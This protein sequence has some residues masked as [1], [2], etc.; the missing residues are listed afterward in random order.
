VGNGDFVIIPGIS[1]ANPIDNGGGNTTTGTTLHTC[2]AANVHN[3][4][5]TYGSMTD[6][7]GNVYKTIVIGTQEWMAENL[8]ASHYRNGDLIPLV[9]DDM[10]WD[11]LTTGATCWYNNDSATYNC[12]YGK[13]YNWYAVADPN[14][15]CPTGWHVPTYSEWSVLRNYFDDV[16]PYYVAASK[17]Q[18]L[19]FQYWFDFGNL[20]ATNESGF[21]AL[22]GGTRLIN[23]IFNSINYSTEWWSNTD[24]GSAY[25]FISA[26]GFN[27]T[28]SI[29]NDKRYGFSVRCLR[30]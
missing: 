4:D 1:E 3:P 5:L 23:G 25:A 9:T 14:N 11:G 29:N 20:D 8:K 24:I 2:G 27:Q 10:T 26:D 17:L 6:Q 7:E 28:T 13:L 15:V 21:S 16:W 30:D 19:G 22:P 12:P 18:S